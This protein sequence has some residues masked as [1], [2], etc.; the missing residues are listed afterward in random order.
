MVELNKKIGL[1]GGSFD[2]IHNGHL[3]IAARAQ[4]LLF[5]DRVI[6]IPAAIPP[7]KQHLTLT[8]KNHRLQMAKLAIENYP[9]FEVSDIEIQRSGISYTIDTLLFF[10]KHFNLTSDQIYFIIGADSLIDFHKWRNP[11]KIIENCNIV[12]YDR[13][14]IDINS[15]GGDLKKKVS[16]LNAPLIDISSTTIRNKIMSGKALNKLLPEKV[17]DYISKNN[18][19]C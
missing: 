14:G 7:H 8:N 1:F 18:L 19:Y 16:F 2:P 4:K 3:M 9:D 10:R 13:A 11:E 6:F 5:I 17:A 15:I 12:V